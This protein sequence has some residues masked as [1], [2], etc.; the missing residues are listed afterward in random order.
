MKEPGKERCKARSI[1]VKGVQL[2]NLGQL[3]PGREVNLE[4]MEKKNLS[5]LA[6]GNRKKRFS[7]HSLHGI[8]YRQAF[9]EAA[10]F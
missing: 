1:G 5:K 7:L 9:S 6:P 4:S 10:N 3:D 8:K 2:P